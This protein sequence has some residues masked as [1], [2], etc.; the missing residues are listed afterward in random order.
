[1]AKGFQCC[2]VPQ[3]NHTWCIA[4]LDNDRVGV[5][6]LWIDLSFSSQHWMLTLAVFSL[7]YQV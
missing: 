7:L 3:D 4:F 2:G 6:G 5:S 1:M